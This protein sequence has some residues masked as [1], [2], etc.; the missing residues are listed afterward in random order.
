MPKNSYLCSIIIDLIKESVGVILISVFVYVEGEYLTQRLGVP[1]QPI[2]LLRRTHWT[3][4]KWH[5][6]DGKSFQVPLCYLCAH[7]KMLHNKYN[8]WLLWKHV[9]LQVNKIVLVYWLTL[10]SQILL[11]THYPQMTM[12]EFWALQALNTQS[13]K[14]H[15]LALWH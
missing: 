9:G 8:L 10:R 5:M 15:D 7:R 1:L 4:T 2:P 12:T 14:C 13:L 11:L 3:V 6:C